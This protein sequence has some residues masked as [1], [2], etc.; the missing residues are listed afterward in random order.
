MEDVCLACGRRI[1]T[2][3]YAAGGIT[4]A[5]QWTHGSRRRD[6][7]HTPIPTTHH[8]YTIVDRR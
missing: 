5:Q 8:D 1:F 3:H 2:V 7:N 4:L 6:R